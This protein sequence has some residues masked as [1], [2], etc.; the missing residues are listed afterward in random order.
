MG[1]ITN[2]IRENQEKKYRDTESHMKANEFILTQL[3]GMNDEDAVKL[4]YEGVSDMKSQIVPVAIKNITETLDKNVGKEYKG[5][6]G[7]FKHLLSGLSGLNPVPGDPNKGQQVPQMDSGRPPRSEEQTQAILQ[8]RQQQQGQEKEKQ[9]QAHEQ[10]FA[11][12]R[13]KE[14]VDTNAAKIAQEQTAADRK[15]TQ[16]LTLLEENKE[17]WKDHQDEY[18][19]L[20]AQVQG[21]GKLPTQ[22]NPPEAKQVK[23]DFAKAIAQERG[24]DVNQL[25]T[26]DRVMIDLLSKDTPEVKTLTQNYHEKGMTWQDSRKKALDQAAKNIN[27]KEKG[28]V[29]NNVTKQE[30]AASA[31]A[32]IP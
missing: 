5:A 3:S 30:A 21:F 6:G 11:D 15:R 19:D 17:L 27:E 16:T 20:Y 28:V 25:T 8:Q 29:I 23:T 1:I 26:Q 2:L 31:G 18:R 10:G 22:R 13:Q 9:A 4:G 32:T 12:I 14:Q 24:I 7:I